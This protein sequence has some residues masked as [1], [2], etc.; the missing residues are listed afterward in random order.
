MLGCCLMHCHVAWWV[1]NLSNTLS[2]LLIAPKFI[3]YEWRVASVCWTIEMQLVAATG[4][5]LVTAGGSRCSAWSHL[6]LDTTTG[7]RQR[8]AEQARTRHTTLATAWRRTHVHMHWE[9][10]LRGKRGKKLLFWDLNEL[11]KSNI[12]ENKKPIKN[13]QRKRNVLWKFCMA[14]IYV[15]ITSL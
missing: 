1:Q 12:K 6:P 2:R 11:K 7:Q 8:W 15:C 9:K 4:W 13:Q 14:I 5:Q 10:Q 3:N